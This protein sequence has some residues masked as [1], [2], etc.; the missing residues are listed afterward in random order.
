MRRQREPCKS[1]ENEPLFI[2]RRERVW[3]FDKMCPRN[4]ELLQEELDKNYQLDRK[5]GDAYI[6]ERKDSG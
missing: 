6:Y 3:Y 5:I 2:I 4:N 1:L